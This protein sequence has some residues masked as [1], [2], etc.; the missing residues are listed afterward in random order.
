M[1]V[2]VFLSLTGFISFSAKNMYCYCNIEV[3]IK[4]FNKEEKK[5]GNSVPVVVK[6]CKNN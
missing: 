4:E 1:A 5:S 2:A 6:G 3:I